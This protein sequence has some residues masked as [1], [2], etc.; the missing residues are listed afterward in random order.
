MN[1][2]QSKPLTYEDFFLLG[3]AGRRIGLYNRAVQWLKMALAANDTKPEIR[4]EIMMTVSFMLTC[5][6][7]GTEAVG[8]LCVVSRLASR[9]AKKAENSARIP[10]PP[11]AA[12]I[13]G[14]FAR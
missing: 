8:L 11:K 5:C 6:P 2:I 3:L 10:V 7:V 1:G 14:D 9:C 13:L 12:F 4:D